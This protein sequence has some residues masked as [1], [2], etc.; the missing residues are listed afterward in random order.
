[1][2][3]FSDRYPAQKLI[4]PLFVFS[5]IGLFMQGWADNLWMFGCGRVLLYIAA[6]G[7][8]SVIQKLLATVT[9]VRKR[10]TAFGLSSTANGSGIMLSSCLSSATFLYVGCSG[11]FYTTAILFL[12]AMP[13]ALFCVNKA[14][15]RP[16]FHRPDSMRA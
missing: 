15:T 11:V 13:F 2:G 3:Y 9:P 1:V 10:G 4:C 5:A 12:L 7:L 14:L 8:P 6:G 16:V